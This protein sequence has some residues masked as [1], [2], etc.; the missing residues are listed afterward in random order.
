MQINRFAFNKTDGSSNKMNNKFVF[1]E[2]IWKWK[3]PY[4]TGPYKLFA[5]LGNN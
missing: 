5:V 3:D 2:T 1:H 4:K